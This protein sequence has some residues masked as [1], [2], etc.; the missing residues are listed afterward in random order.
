[1]MSMVLIRCYTQFFAKFCRKGNAVRS[2]F[3]YTL[4]KFVKRN[5]GT[6]F[7]FFKDSIGRDFLIS[8]PK[9]TLE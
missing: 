4:V 1:M 7:C 3:Y 9:D 5:F 2:E 8:V 6:A